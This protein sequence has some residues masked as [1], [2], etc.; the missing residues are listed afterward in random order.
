MSGE[1]ELGRTLRPRTKVLPEQA[2][3]HNRSLVLQTLYRDRGQSRAD[4]ARATGLTRVTISDL[5]AELVAEG[6]IVELG[7]RDEARPGK[8]AVLL[9]MNAEYAQIVGLDL[10]EDAYFRGAV[11]D[12][13]GTVL[14]SRD[15]PL[16]GAT[17]ERA[18]TL[19]LELA[20]ALAADAT[21]PLLGI[22]VGSP[23]IVDPTGVVVSAPNLGW[24]A[25]ELQQ[26]VREHTGSA[27]YVGNDANVAVLAEYGFG[28]ALGDMMLVKVGHGVGAGLLVGGALVY[29]SRFAAGEIGQVMVD[30]ARG[31]YDGARSLEASLAVPQLRE[32][33]GHATSAGQDSEAVL[34][35]AGRRLAI[36]LAPIVGAL[37]LAEV[38]LS[39]PEDLLGGALTDAAI[40]TLRE[41]T[42]AGFHT[43]VQLRMTA[44]GRDI[45]VR[46][47]GVMVL[48][49]QLGVS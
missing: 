6:V 33:L 25:L 21:A 18:V 14:A 34:A 12:L 30:S 41:R 37:N 17:G 26:R 4:L 38:V 7:Q 11:L 2:R 5:V 1:F 36:V 9:D 48:S 39:G 46:G 27:A 44:L 13:H 49:G 24:S 10:S 20:D 31:P 42:M 16:D 29:G 35:D 32:R 15:V 23:G 40:A 47:A 19:V 45:V 3:A 8:P 43:D 22:G 28:Q